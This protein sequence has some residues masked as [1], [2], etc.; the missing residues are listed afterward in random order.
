M[1]IKGKRVLVTGGSG[2]IGKE[3]IK[4][5]IDREAIIMN[6]DLVPLPN[7][8]FDEVSNIEIDLAKDYLGFLREF[9][10]EIIFHLAAKFERSTESP[11]FWE[12]NWNN[13]VVLSHRIVD[14]LRYM[15]KCKVF[16]FASSYLIYDTNLYM[17]KTPSKVTY[18]K[19]D[20][21]VNPRNICGA[22]KYYTEKELR[23]IQKCYNPSMRAINA[24]IYRVY[25]INSSE[26]INRW[27]DLY[28][29]GEKG[30]VYKKEN[31]FDLIYSRDVAEG[32]LRLACSTADGVVN[33][34][35]GK[36][37]S[38]DNVINIIGDIVPGFKEKMFD[39]FDDKGGYEASCADLTKLD[40]FTGWTPKT[41]LYTGLE[42]V[43]KGKYGYN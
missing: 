12:N 27:I 7:K 9:D 28:L 18:L 37:T 14:M 15:D 38:I 17:S 1:N 19:E 4:M 21:Q 29:A 36:A 34:G 33:L 10:P 20:S 31:C 32:L 2:V 43:I 6:A 3:L 40:S 16:V 24:R 35:S 39:Y 25:G 22:S 5:L 30:F 41:Q 26:I 11:G 8:G 13:N 23:F 42:E